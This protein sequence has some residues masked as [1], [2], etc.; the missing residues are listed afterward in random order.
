[1]KDI[2]G[3]PVSFENAA[4]VAALDAGIAQLNAYRGDPVGSVAAA[5][6]AHPDFAM[7]HIFLAALFATAMDRT[8]VA[9]TERALKAA[10]PLLGGA[11]DRE[12]AHY[13]AARR[14]ADGDIAGATEKWGR[15]AM[16]HPHDILAIQLGQ[17]G[18]FFQ[19]QSLMLRD[20]VL[21]V[22]PKW[23]ADV[24]GHGF[25][26]G[27]LSFGHE[28]AGEYARAEALGRAAVEAEP[29]D[30]WAAHAVAHVLEMEG[31]VPHGLD[32][33]EGTKGGWD[34]DGLL[35]YHLWWHA[36]LMRIDRG[37][38]AET[39]AIYDRHIAAGGLGQA[40]ELVDASALL[41]RLWVLGHDVGPRWREVADKWALRVQHGISAFNDVH[42]VMAFAALGMD[43]EVDAQIA[44]L[45]R[46]AAGSDTNAVM[47]RLA[48]LPVARGFAAFGRGDYAGALANL[49]EAMPRAAAFGGSHAQRDVLGWTAMEAA[50]RAGDRAAA[51][52]LLAERMG[53]KSEAAPTHGWLRRT[54]ALK[55]AS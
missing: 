13:A 45:E 23:S 20:R 54:E 27:M 5:L 28:E 26:L 30:A 32:W 33:I 10:A 36:G 37:D 3:N 35:A 21:R 31:R 41:W 17:Q 40:L 53:R 24:P 4:A 38:I 39:L 7:G 47:A 44:T 19:G 8:L 18:D 46:S 1:M 34:E 22:S 6:K 14:W 43:A 11:N 52:A 2:Q 55:R 16:D 29:R 15:I 42:A 48:G 9:H 12:R 50:V 51:D 25:V 49:M